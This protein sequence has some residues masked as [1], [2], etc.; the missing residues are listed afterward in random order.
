MTLDQTI[1]QLSEVVTKVLFEPAPITEAERAFFEPVIAPVREFG[2]AVEE[3]QRKF[4]RIDRRSRDVV[5]AIEA[6]LREL[7]GG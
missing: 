5:E 1:Q 4:G 6:F 2:R 7:F 3:T